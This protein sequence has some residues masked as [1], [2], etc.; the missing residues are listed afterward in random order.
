M[1]RYFE[2]AVDGEVV[3]IGIYKNCYVYAFS[4]ALF[5][6]LTRLLS[7]HHVAIYTMM[8]HPAELLQPKCYH[9]GQKG[10]QAS[11]AIFK[12]PYLKYVQNV[13]RSPLVVF[14]SSQIGLF[15]YDSVTI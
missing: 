1:Q 13:I 9:I 7:T 2:I 3:Y 4:L 8:Y 12:K 6:S 15:N 5:K 11:M 10:G 14:D